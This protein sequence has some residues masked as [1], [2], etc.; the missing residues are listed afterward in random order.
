MHSSSTKSVETCLPSNLSRRAE[1]SRGL[2]S[3]EHGAGSKLIFLGCLWVSHDVDIAWSKQSKKSMQQASGGRNSSSM[4]I[5]RCNR[6]KLGICGNLEF[7][8]KHFNAVRPDMHAPHFSSHRDQAA[9]DSNGLALQPIPAPP[10]DWRMQP[11]AA[12]HTL[13]QHHSRPVH[14]HQHHNLLYG[15][16]WQRRGGRIKTF[17]GTIDTI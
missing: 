2:A 10:V 6:F 11:S 7:L 13:F 3:R 5:Y 16:W 17:G 14:L 8:H 12:Q 1:A 15:E 9:V 4:K